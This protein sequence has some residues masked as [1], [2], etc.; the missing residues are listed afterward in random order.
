M[1]DKALHK[2]I[3]G[4]DA[5]SSPMPS[6][7]QPPV[8]SPMHPSQGPHSHAMIYAHANMAHMHAAPLPMHDAPPGVLGPMGP[9]M[10]LGMPLVYL[11]SD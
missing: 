5:S 3:K 2:K 1:L 4:S 8:P 9:C 7:A 11:P 10:G 6:N